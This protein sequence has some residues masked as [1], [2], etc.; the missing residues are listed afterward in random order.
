MQ[1]AVVTEQE[2]LTARKVLLAK[3]KELTHLRDQVRQAR[4]ELPWVKVTKQ[5]T[6]DTPSGK[7]TLADLFD[8][9]SQ[10][11]IQHFMLG[12]GDKAGCPMCSLLADEYDGILSHLENHD[13]SLVAV[14]RGTLPEIESYKKRMGWRFP[15][16][17][18]TGTDFN[19]DYNVSF[20]AEKNP[21]GKGTY[22]Y[23]EMP[24]PPNLAGME[25]PGMSAF[26]KNEAG[27]V[28]HTYSC[29]ARGLEDV[30]GVLM[31]LDRAPLGRNEKG[32]MDFVRRHDEYTNPKTHSC[33]S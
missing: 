18:S 28:F 20:S 9:R 4:Q 27:E 2:W 29:Y 16:V 33:C 32:T 3:E 5:Y 22:N 13:V 24:L 23:S 31:L 10:L 14:S 7:K 8:G 19:F 1:H 12:P 15:W 11:L 26:A 21:N 17:S 6:F 25:L 30:M